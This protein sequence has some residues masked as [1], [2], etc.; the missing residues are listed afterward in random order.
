MGL[1]YA[2]LA[3]H[4]ALAYGLVLAIGHYLAFFLGFAEGI[5]PGL[6]YILATIY[7][8]TAAGAA[9]SPIILAQRL[10]YV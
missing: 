6:G 8:L 3:A 10:G 2:A 4:G 5:I 9:L 7:G 1:R